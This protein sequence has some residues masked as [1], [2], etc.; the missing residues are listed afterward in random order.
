MAV[1]ILP[2]I[3]V[4]CTIF[5]FHLRSFQI[6]LVTK[7]LHYARCWWN[8]MVMTTVPLVGMRMSEWYCE[9][10]GGSVCCI[11]V[12]NVWN[13]WWCVISGCL[14]EE[15]SCCNTK[16]TMILMM[17]V[18]IT[19]ITLSCIFF[20]K[21]ICMLLGSEIS[22]WVVGGALHWKIL[23]LIWPVL[24]WCGVKATR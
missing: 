3:I 16:M 19:I 5:T 6:K 23:C 7:L 14:D 9:S 2:Y 24:C 12:N 18:M 1:V 10:W 17:M 21:L 15:H 22:A 11:N 13:L 20:L 4:I 8:M